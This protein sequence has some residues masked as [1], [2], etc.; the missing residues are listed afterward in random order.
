MAFSKE[1][2]ESYLENIST[3]AKSQFVHLLFTFLNVLKSTKNI[4]L[5][6]EAKLFFPSHISKISLLDKN[7][8]C[9]FLQN[10]LKFSWHFILFFLHACKK[11]TGK[12]Y[13]VDK[14]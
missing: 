12:I 10:T 5:G 3:S 4:F 7:I 9:F 1:Q 2:E 6:A 8:Q 14:N 11:Y 13:S